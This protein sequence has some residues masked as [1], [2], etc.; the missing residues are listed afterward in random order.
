MKIKFREFEKV[1]GE[2]KDGSIWTAY[3]IHGSVLESDNQRR[4]G[5][6]W[7]STNIFD[8]ESTKTV[9]GKLFDLKAGDKVNVKHEKTRGGW[10]ITDIVPITDEDV[11]TT[12][13]KSAGGR[14]TANGAKSQS[15]GDTMSKAEWAEKN[16]T[17]RLSIAK[18][19]ALKAAVENT[20]LGTPA[21]SLIEMADELVP[22]LIDVEG[23]K[24]VVK[25]DG[26]DPLDPPNK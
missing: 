3:K 25:D 10:S 9:L 13:K 14:G 12:R 23:Y 17:D 8:Q 4:A 18:S 11:Y 7:R 26:S 2:K 15:G 22:W 24:V 16:R 5:D 20:K 19:V 6:D 21:G 1:Q